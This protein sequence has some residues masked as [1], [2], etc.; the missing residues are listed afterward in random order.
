MSV[1]IIRAMKKN[2]KKYL[3]QD[4]KLN[5]VLSGTD[6]LCYEKETHGVPVL[7]KVFGVVAVLKL[8]PII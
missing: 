1:C 6:L 4:S 8:V 5:S 2:G 7:G 3:E